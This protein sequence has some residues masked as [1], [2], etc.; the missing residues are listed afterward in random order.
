MRR[1]SPFGRRSRPADPGRPAG[2]PR[3]PRRPG[4]VGSYGPHPTRPSCLE[5][6]I[7]TIK[8]PMEAL[9]CDQRSMEIDYR[10][11]WCSWPSRCSAAVHRRGQ[12]RAQ[13]GQGRS[14]QV[15]AAH[16]T[17]RVRGLI[18]G[19]ASDNW[20]E[21]VGRGNWR[22]QSASQHPPHFRYQSRHRALPGQL[23]RSLLLVVGPRP[24]G[25]DANALAILR[26]PGFAERPA[27]TTRVEGT[28]REHRRQRVQQLQD[29]P[30]QKLPRTVNRTVRL[31]PT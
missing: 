4:H 20:N 11:P 22:R 3:Q 24:L 27:Q 12:G 14:G 13:G 16:R 23:A 19:A 6:R 10:R 2:G 7:S 15:C 9:N 29:I 21:S 26:Q 28:V 8:G 30:P 5:I 18:P 31:L 17:V 25:V 1:M